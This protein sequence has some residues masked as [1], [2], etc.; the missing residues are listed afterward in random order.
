VEP[1]GGTMMGGARTSYSFGE[2]A[3]AG[4][5]GTGT[6]SSSGGTAAETGYDSKTSSSPTR[7][8][9]AL[10]TSSSPTCVTPNSSFIVS[11]VIYKNSNIP[12]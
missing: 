6:S 10:G 3:I 9:F 5:Y 12:K 4:P 2:T 11:N 7:M 1:Y 8:H